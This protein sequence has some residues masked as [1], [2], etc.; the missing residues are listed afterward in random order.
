MFSF[1][2]F[3]KSVSFSELCYRCCVSG[4]ECSGRKASLTFVCALNNPFL[5]SISRMLEKDFGS[6]IIFI[7]GNKMMFGWEKCSFLYNRIVL[8]FLVGFS[9]SLFLAVLSTAPWSSEWQTWFAHTNRVHQIAR[10]VRKS[11]EMVFDPGSGRALTHAY[12]SK[13]KLLCLPL[14]WLVL[15]QLHYR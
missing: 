13:K 8:E 5:K 2:G 12:P 1:L 15:A 9:R 6:F 10:S 4:R 7:P 14:P 11:E 3:L